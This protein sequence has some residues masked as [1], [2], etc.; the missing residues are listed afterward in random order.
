MRPGKLPCIAHLVQVLQHVKDQ[1]PRARDHDAK[2]YIDEGDT[3]PSVSVTVGW[4]SDTG[5]WSYQTGA[6]SFMGSAYSYPLW[7]VVSVY[8]TS[9]CRAVARDIVQQLDELTW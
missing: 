5:D 1:V 7:A 3:L 2:D 6:N 4:R 8:R 9:N